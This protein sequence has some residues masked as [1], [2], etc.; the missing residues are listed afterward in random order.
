MDVGLFKKIDGNEVRLETEKSWSAPLGPI[1]VNQEPLSAL[2]RGNAAKSVFRVTSDN[3]GDLAL[4]DRFVALGSFRSADRA[5]R[6]VARFSHL[7][8][9]V[10]LVN[11]AGQTWNRVSVGPLNKRDALTLRERYDRIDGQTTWSFMKK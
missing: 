1:A 10:M 2:P 8:P 3:T 9:Q 4:K 5:G 6:L 11:L 7:K